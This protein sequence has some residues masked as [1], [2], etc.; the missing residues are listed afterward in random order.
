MG[1]VFQDYLLFPHLSVVENVAF[2]LRSKGENV[3]DS[4]ADAMRFLAEV[5]AAELA[6]RSPGDL[7]GGQAQRVALARALASRPQM[8]LL[9]EPFAAL[10]VTTRGQL[11]GQVADHLA[12][13]PGPRLLITHEPTEAFLLADTVHVIEDGSLTQ[14]GSAE[15]I[16]LRPRTSYIADL[17][18]LNLLRGNAVGG[19]VDVA[20]HP[21][22]TAADD[23][24]GPA[25]A[26]IHPRAIALYLVRP[27]GSPRNSWQ[28]SITRV[29]RLGER[30]R[31]QTE[32]PVPL[33]AE[34]TVGA[35]DALHLEPG[36][37]VWLTVKATEID[38][39]AAD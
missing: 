4:Q 20:G 15:E 26:V 8:L 27:E 9:D 18:G 17:A 38:V 6:E 3:P 22:H 36:A 35:L 16:R 37:R 5:G 19:V 10:D 13:F 30:V 14:V 24:E 31:V 7:S 25:I 28:T 2:P 1:I 12:R 33:T 32:D 29:E 34:I 21:I 11:R 39:Q 23:I